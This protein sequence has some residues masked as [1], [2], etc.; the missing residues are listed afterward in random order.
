MA[1]LIQITAHASRNYA[2]CDCL[3]NKLCYCALLFTVRPMEMLSCTCQIVRFMS[4][5]NICILEPSYN[6]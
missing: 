1:F 6:L 2:K 5:Q 4:D 3:N